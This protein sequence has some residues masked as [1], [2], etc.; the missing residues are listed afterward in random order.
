[1]PER[2]TPLHTWQSHQLS[3]THV[4]CLKAKIQKEIEEN[5]GSTWSEWRVKLSDC[6]DQKNRAKIGNT[7]E[8]KYD[9][10]ESY[11]GLPK[12]GTLLYTWQ[13][14]QSNNGAGSLNAKIRKE[15]AKNEEGTVWSERRVQLANCVAQKRRE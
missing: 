15:K 2:G 3:N 8:E 9:E 13:Q 10:F 1:M 7:W 11:D 6:V 4:S 5:E 12:K 14:N